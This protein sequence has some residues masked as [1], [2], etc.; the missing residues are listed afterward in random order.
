MK[1]KF[2]KSISVDEFCSDDCRIEFLS[3]QAMKNLKKIKN[4]ELA[5]WK[6]RKKE[7]RISAHRVKNKSVLQKEINKLSRMIDMKCGI[8][9]CIDCGKKLEQE[10]QIDASHR[11]NSSDYESIRYN[12][13]NLHSS[14]SECNNHHSGRLDVYDKK[15]EQ[16]YG[17]DYAEFVFNLPETYS[18]LKFTDK[19]IFE[20]IPK[21]RK[22]QRILKTMTSSS[23]IAL[24]SMLNILI[25]LYSKNNFIQ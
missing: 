1:C 22:L 6:M 19:E 2:C 25:G 23:P 4:D 24:R 15:L 21:V 14:R 12:L 3:L 18:G 17:S 13:H 8:D 10:K 11:W 5:Q 20:A 9:S 7:M 16:K